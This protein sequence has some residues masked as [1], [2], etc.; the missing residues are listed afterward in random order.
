MKTL[1]ASCCALLILTTACSSSQDAAEIDSPVTSAEIAETTTPDS[2]EG[3]DAGDDSPVDLAQLSEKG[4]CSG[5]KESSEF[6]PFTTEWGTCTFE[7]TEVQ[8]YEFPNQTA[9][10][11]FFK[12]V[13]GF[14][15]LIEQVAVKAD[16]SGKFYVWAPDDSTKRDSLKAIFED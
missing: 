15:V 16:E 10:D 3:A 6:A 11:E 1:S 2:T 12:T 5:Y 9:L 14:G 13:S 8:A 7:G 4:G